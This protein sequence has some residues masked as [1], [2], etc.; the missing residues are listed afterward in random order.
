M[1]V[2]F[3]GPQHMHV[4]KSVASKTWGQIRQMQIFVQ[5][6]FRDH[7]SED[8]TMCQNQ[9]LFFLGD[10][11]KHFLACLPETRGKYGKWSN[12]ATIFSTDGQKT[13]PSFFHVAVRLLLWSQINLNSRATSTIWTNMFCWEHPHKTMVVVYPS[14]WLMWAHEQRHRAI[15]GTNQ[16][17]NRPCC[18]L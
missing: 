14:K 16:G 15:S 11:F 5:W 2:G 8:R 17:K 3:L 7:W 18:G 10:G 6:N 12:L 1:N 4:W 9:S 13:S